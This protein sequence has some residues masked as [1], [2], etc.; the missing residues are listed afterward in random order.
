VL[1]NVI[2]LVQKKSWDKAVAILPGGDAC[3]IARPEERAI[4][5]LHLPKVAIFHFA[6]NVRLPN[7]AY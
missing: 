1:F 6:V 7:I 2:K 3:D 5:A 4:L